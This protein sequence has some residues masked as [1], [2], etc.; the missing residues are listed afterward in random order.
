VKI[1]ITDDHKIVREGLKEILKHLPEITLIDEA[2]DGKE[3]LSKISGANFELIL[4]DI[5]L[6]DTT[7]LEI[8][9]T[10]MK[11][12]PQQK[13]LMLSMHPQE[14]YAVRALNLGASGYLTKDTASEELIM[15]VKKITSGGKYISASLIENITMHFNKDFSKPPHESLS[16]RE[17]GVL[18]RIASGKSLQEIGNELFISA[19]TVSTYRARIMEKLGMKKN[20]ELTHYCLRNGLLE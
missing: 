12:Y 3:A 19:K 20:A 4:L 10:I 5:S 8:L 16:E 18:L 9:E 15:A 6:P 17:F 7:G 2:K 14:Q 13:V 11:K 1:L